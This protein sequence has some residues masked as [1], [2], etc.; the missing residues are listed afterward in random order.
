MTD[1]Y[2]RDAKRTSPRVRWFI[3]APIAVTATLLWLY[4]ESRVWRIDAEALQ[5]LIR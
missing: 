3:W 4:F 1:A 5:E 2:E